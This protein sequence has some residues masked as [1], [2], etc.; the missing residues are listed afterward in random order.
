MIKNLN[1]RPDSIKLLE[2]NIEQRV[3]DIGLG[4][5]YFGYGTKSKNNKSKNLA[6]LHQTHLG[7]Y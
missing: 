3:F 7:T 5:N 2:E 1:V 6:G 4:N